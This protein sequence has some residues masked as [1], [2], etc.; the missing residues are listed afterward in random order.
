M[1]ITRASDYAVRVMVHLATLPEGKKAQ[2]NTLAEMTEVRGTFL[3]KILQRLVHQGFVSS[4]RGTGG[5]FCLKVPAEQVTLLQVI[6]S[7]EGSM[8]LN[9]CL[10]EGPSCARKSWCGV[11]PVWREAQS[12]LTNV[13]GAMSVAELAKTSTANLSKRGEAEE[14][15]IAERS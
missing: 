3:S 15:V 5:G 4:Y 12:A 2:L 13:L 11:H 6:E 10:K 14:S 8:Q 7:M 9:V 1:Q